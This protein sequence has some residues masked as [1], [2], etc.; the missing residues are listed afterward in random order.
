[1]Y[2]RGGTDILTREEVYTT[3]M[4]QTYSYDGTLVKPVFQTC[5][6]VDATLF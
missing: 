3:T 5:I 1:M 4:V 2:H 6:S